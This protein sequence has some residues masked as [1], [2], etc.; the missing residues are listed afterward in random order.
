MTYGYIVGREAASLSYFEARLRAATDPEERK[1]LESVVR[2]I[3]SAV[4][5]RGA[6]ATPGE[7]VWSQ[8]LS[9][10]GALRRP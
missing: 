8:T 3:K 9:N 6:G 4:E 2:N 10:Q 5:V 1:A 7:R